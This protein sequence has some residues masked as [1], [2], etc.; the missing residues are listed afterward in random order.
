MNWI[1]FFILFVLF[2]AMLNGYRRGFLKEFSTSLGLVIG[3]FIAVDQAD[4]LASVLVGKI[5]ISQSILYVIS[6]VT[7]FG[8]CIVILKILGMY[9]YKVN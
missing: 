6:F 4:W 5:S 3:V 7:I 9:F 1:D 2:L 8:L